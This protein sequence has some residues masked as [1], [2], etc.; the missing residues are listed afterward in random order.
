MGFDKTCRQIS[1]FFV[2]LFLISILS[3]SNIR[4]EG[5]YADITIDVDSSGFV[6]IDGVT[7][8]PGLLVNN[9]QSY[10]LKKQSY[11]LLNITIEDVFSDFVYAMT[12]PEDS[13]IN[14]I[15]SSGFI[16][17]QEDQGNLLVKVLER[18]NPFL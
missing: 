5:Y 16:Q 15:K 14:Y 11:W 10:T 6:T 17:I 13:S 3:F 8:Y 18:M 4:A 9:T 12:L 7:N 2:L 1:L